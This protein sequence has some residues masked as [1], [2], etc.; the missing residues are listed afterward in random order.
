MVNT[1][2]DDW[3]EDSIAKVLKAG[4]EFFPQ[5]FGLIVAHARERAS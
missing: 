4:V 5:A 3:P 1:G 2:F